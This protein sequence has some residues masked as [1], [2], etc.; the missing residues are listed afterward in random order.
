MLD[1]AVI[2]FGNMGRQFTEH[3]H[4]HPELNARI[5]AV[6]NRGEKN[7]TIAER[8][9]GLSATGSVEELLA[10]KLDFVLVASQSN[11]HADHVVEAAKAGC[12]IFCEKP[13]ALAL[14]DADRMIAAAEQADVITAVN[15][16]MR[17]NFGYRRIKEMADSG[18]LGELLSVSH[19]KSRGYGLYGA[20][21]RHRAIVEP[22]ESGGWTVHHACHDLDFLYWIGGPIKRVCAAVQSTLPGKSSEEIVLGIVE[23]ESGA[24]GSIGDSVCGIRDHY[25]RLIGAKASLVMTGENEH[26]QCRFRREGAHAEE[27]LP[28]EDRKR[29]GNGLD[30]FFDCVNRGVKSPHSLAEARHSLAAALAMRAS[31]HSAA[32]VELSTL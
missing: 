21:A 1:G 22:E 26:T 20:G 5:V 23:F 12:H 24:I 15:Y 3:I 14:A 31:A 28:I 13:I 30:H 10:Q 2:G 11:A 27:Q 8:D 6:C 19:A 29:P 16:I 17:F 9:Y 18:E 32:P 7:R 4:A 25:T